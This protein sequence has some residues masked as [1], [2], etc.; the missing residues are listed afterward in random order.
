MTCQKSSK[1][2]THTHNIFIEDQRK[3][4]VVSVWLSVASDDELCHLVFSF[5]FGWKSAKNVTVNRKHCVWS[6]KYATEKEKSKNFTILFVCL[7]V[8][9]LSAYSISVFK[10]ENEKWCAA[11]PSHLIK[12]SKR[13]KK[14]VS[15]FLCFYSWLFFSLPL[16]RC[17]VPFDAFSN[18]ICSSD[19]ILWFE[20]KYT[21]LG[22]CHFDF[23]FMSWQTAWGWT[24]STTTTLVH[25]QFD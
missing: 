2:K 11:N 15:S 17:I 7:F 12:N 4:S 22:T 23:T 13:I 14:N 9:F 8:C 5:L 16:I 10:K 3:R 25:I 21:G 19:S 24:A 18:I 6:V 1:N 20:F